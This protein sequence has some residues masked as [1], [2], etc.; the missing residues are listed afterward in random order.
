MTDGID[1]PFRLD[2][3]QKGLEILLYQKDDISA[4]LLAEHN[5]AKNISKACSLELNLISKN[6]APITFL[7]I[8]YNLLIYTP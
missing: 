4:K 8:Y 7:Q 5:P 2:R 1:A 3:N 6:M